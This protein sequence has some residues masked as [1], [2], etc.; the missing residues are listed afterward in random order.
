MTSMSIK[1]LALVAAVRDRLLEDHRIAALAIDVSCSD[2]SVCLVGCVDNVE[3]KELA[4]ELITGLVGVR[5]VKEEL[6]VRK[7]G[8]AMR[9]G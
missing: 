3:Q 6:R 7:L 1:N 4:V 5:N 2:G 9:A 8:P